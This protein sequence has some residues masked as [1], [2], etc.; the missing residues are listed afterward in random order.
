MGEHQRRRLDR[1]IE[2]MTSRSPALRRFVAAIRG[3]R[4]MLLRV[5]LGIVLVAGGFLAILPIFGLWMVPIGL[6]ILAMD[7]PVLRP[8]VSAAIIRGRRGWA[9]WRR[10]D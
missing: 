1:Q 5:P 9:L 7:L 6:L 2:A 4:G 3:R 8:A 10:K